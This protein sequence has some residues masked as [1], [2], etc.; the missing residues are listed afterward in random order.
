LGP[1]LI[2]VG[3]LFLTGSLLY[4]F[5]S[6]RSVVVPEPTPR[7]SSTRPRRPA[8]RSK[9]GTSQSV[10]SPAEENLAAYCHRCGTKFREDAVFCH[11]CGAERRGE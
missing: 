7:R 10:P 1:V 9:P 8:R 4:W 2:V 5:W 3:V 11:A 6:Q